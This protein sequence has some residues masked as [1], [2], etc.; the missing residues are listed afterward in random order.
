MKLGSFIEKHN[1]KE[2]L[3]FDSENHR[4]YL[5]GGELVSVTKKI[6]N[7]FPFNVDKVSKYIADLNL[8]SQEEVLKEWDIIR[9]EG[10]YFHDLVD[11]YFKKGRLKKEELKLIRPVLDFLEEYN[12]SVEASEARVF[13]EKYKIAGT[14][15]LIARDESGKLFL[16]DWKTNRKVIDKNSFFENASIP[17]NEFPNNKFFVYSLQTSCYALILEEEYGIDIYDNRIVHIRD[18]GYEVIDVLT[19]L[20]EAKILFRE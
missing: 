15:D 16:I 14:V 6:S 3:T 5:K 9:E 11:K 20:E 1:E 13:S 8:T 2:G 18:S 12:F 4:Y 19:M 17:F 10:S 7:Y